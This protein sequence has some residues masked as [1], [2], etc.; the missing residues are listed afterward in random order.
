[1][2]A[3]YVDLDG[4]LVYTDL[5]VESALRFVAL[6][7]FQAY[8]LLFWLARGKAH[9]KAQLA[10]RV[11]LDPSALPYNVAL[12]DHLTRL[13]AQGT[14]LYLATAA[15]ERYA[16]AVARHLGIFSGVLAS[17]E[18]T[19]LSSTQKLAAI[20]LCAGEDFVYAGNSVDD[21]P[22]WAH[23][24]GALV[25]EGSASV[26]RDIDARRVPLLGTFDRKVSRL[27][28]LLRATRPHQ[29]LKNLL[30]LLPV[31]PIA[32]ARP[33]T[34][35]LLGTAAAFVAFCACASAV[36]LINDLADL[37]ADRAHPRKRKRPFAAG[38]ISPLLGLV[39]APVLL[40]F[41]GALAFAL[42]GAFLLTLCVYL[43]VTLAYTFGLKRHP[44]V[45]V[46]VLAALY[47]LRVLAGAAAIGVFPSFWML[48]FSMFM[49]FSL[50]LAKRYIELDTTSSTL[51]D[52]GA[53]GYRARDM[54]S[55]L[56][57]GVAS[58]YLAVLVVALYINSPD[59]TG[60]YGDVSVLWG[61]CPLLLLWI[62]R[63]WLK[64]ARS[65]V[66]DDP[67]VFALTDR[68]SL[69]IIALALCVLLLAIAGG[70]SATWNQGATR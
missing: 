34:P 26:L 54:P 37:A 69:L 35:M 38:E 42:G 4:T 12:L 44:I 48:A 1:M 24:R 30:V 56:S 66:H 64:S 57:M 27:S 41:A 62:S 6:R 3:V 14:P 60:R 2:T 49:F 46:L 39:A 28:T 51:L 63:V 65:E 25:V 15:N 47:T 16:D 58:G 18:S 17:N 70:P 67:L 52:V 31:L 10:Q 11:E 36:Y 55:L 53:R 33:L 23:S 45:D 21:L 20:Q 19:N 29:W 8:R 5:L 13:A 32:G 9:L 43:L 68:S 7:P 40:G 61:L 59:I 22:I 50:A